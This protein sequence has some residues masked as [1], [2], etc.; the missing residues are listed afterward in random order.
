VSGQKTWDEK[1]LTQVGAFTFNIWAAPDG[2]LLSELKVKQTIENNVE[3]H[4]HLAAMVA[5]LQSYINSDEF[6]QIVEYHKA[7]FHK[8][9][10]MAEI[11]PTRVVPDT[12]KHQLALPFKDPHDKKEK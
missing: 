9:V 6:G 7:K 2:G 10:E 1:D 12:I 5:T 11:K 3:V 4:V 8:V